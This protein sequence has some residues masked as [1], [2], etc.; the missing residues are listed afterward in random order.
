MYK[1]LTNFIPKY[2]IKSISIN[3]IMKFLFLA[4]LNKFNKFNSQYNTNVIR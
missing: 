3:N 2:T 1:N 4:S